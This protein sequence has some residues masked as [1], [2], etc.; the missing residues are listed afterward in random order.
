LCIFFVIQ[1]FGINRYAG[2]VKRMAAMALRVP[3]N[4][5]LALLSLIY[6]IVQ[7]NSKLLRMF[8]EEII[9]CG[10]YLPAAKDP[11]VSN[12]LSSSLL[13]ELGALK[14]NPHS[15]VRDFANELIK[16]GS[17]D[18]GRARLLPLH[19][20]KDPLEFLQIQ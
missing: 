10:V 13:E 4:V 12:A 9:G 19:L 2:F 3:P 1:Q 15:H 8:D 7:R 17:D 16:R 6:K 18:F 11:E 5:A 20:R 14:S